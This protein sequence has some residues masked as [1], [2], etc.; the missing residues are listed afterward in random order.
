MAFCLKIITVVF[1]SVCV[2][3]LVSPQ[4]DGL[5]LAVSVIVPAFVP[6]PS[7]GEG[8]LKRST[9]DQFCQ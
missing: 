9:S 7:K 1:K 8:T 2:I 5:Y 3:A 6:F 4:N